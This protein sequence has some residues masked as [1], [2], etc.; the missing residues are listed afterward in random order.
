MNEEDFNRF[1]AS[2]TRKGFKGKGTLIRKGYPDQRILIL[3][4]MVLGPYSVGYDLHEIVSLLAYFYQKMTE[5]HSR[6][7][8]IGLA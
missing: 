1:V 3:R 6:K 5:K 4:L 2:L 8:F 7:V